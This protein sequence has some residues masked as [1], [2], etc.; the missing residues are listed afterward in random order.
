[1]FLFS[2]RFF[3]ATPF[4]AEFQPRLT[5]SATRALTPAEDFADK[6]E[7]MS[8]WRAALEKRHGRGISHK[9]LRVWRTFWK[10]MLGMKAAHSSDPSMRIR[11]LAPALRWQRWFEGEAVRLAKSAWRNGYHGLACIIA[12]A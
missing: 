5:N 11:N 7:M 4:S 1:L 8:R 6:F 10:I 12:V 2:Q 3:R 9:T